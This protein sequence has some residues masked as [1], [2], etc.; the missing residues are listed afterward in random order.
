MFLYSLYWNFCFKMWKYYEC[1]NLLIEEIFRNKDINEK[2][3]ELNYENKEKD[4]RI[5]LSNENN[6]YYN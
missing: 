2:I 6:N 5:N 1:F 4:D 3:N